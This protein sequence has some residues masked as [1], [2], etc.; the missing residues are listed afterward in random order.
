M[1]FAKKFAAF[2]AA[3]AISATGLVAAS[4]VAAN[5]AD[6]TKSV[7]YNCDIPGFGTKAVS[8]EYSIPALPAS[9]PA[10]TKVPGKAITA[11]VTLPADVANIIV[12]GFGGA[13]SGTLNGNV[14]F[15][16]QSVA[17]S[18]TIPEGRRSPMAPRTPHS[19][20]PAR[21]LASRRAPSACRPSSSPLLSVA[22]S[23]ASASIA[24]RRALTWRSRRSM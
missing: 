1:S 8:A 18:I 11:K 10:G 21:W 16:S 13:I 4:G 3:A 22:F 9:I 20:R 23:V 24:P 6:V 15:G 17:S 14:A 2:G 7:A 19:T 12:V 5:A